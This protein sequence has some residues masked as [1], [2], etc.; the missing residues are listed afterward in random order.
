MSGTPTRVL[1]N[2]NDP[3][4]AHKTRRAVR[5]ASNK[6]SA[7]CTPVTKYYVLVAAQS[8]SYLDAAARL[9]ETCL[10]DTVTSARGQR[11][12][13][14][15]YNHLTHHGH[16]VYVLTEEETVVGGLAVVAS[17]RR[18]SPLAL[19]LHRPESWILAIR[20]LGFSDLFSKLRDLLAVR[21]QA[22]TLK[23]HDYIVALFVDEG[24][25]RQG[26]ARQL[27]ERAINDSSARGVGLAVDTALSNVAA[28]T[29]YAS[30]GFVGHSRTS[31]SVILTRSLE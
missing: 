10:R 8:S 28:Q 26:L 15:S 7:K 11:N 2:W 23:N 6:N 25:R 5:D 29:L 31:R 24:V 12:I 3:L 20:R 22:R 30:L 18:Y 17:N 16:T 9:H 19:L 27:L 13:Q 21:R 1:K 4:G 14:Y